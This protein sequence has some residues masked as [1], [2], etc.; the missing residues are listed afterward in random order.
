MGL[1]HAR[2]AAVSEEPG[3]VP[4]GADGMGEDGMQETRDASESTWGS[5]QGDGLHDWPDESRLCV[6]NSPDR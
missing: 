3:T 1:L 6:P 4:D 5:G 2:G